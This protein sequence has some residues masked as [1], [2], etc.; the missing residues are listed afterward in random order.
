MTTTV[1]K[2]EICRGETVW[3]TIST[4]KAITG[5]VYNKQ[6]RPCEPVLEKFEL[7]VSVWPEMYLA[8][9]LRKWSRNKRRE[10]PF[11]TE[12]IVMLT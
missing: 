2:R 10:F 7:T 11:L 5:K 3:D 4:G 6:R 8:Y 9:P 1:Q 12:L